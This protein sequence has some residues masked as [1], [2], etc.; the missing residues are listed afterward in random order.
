MAKYVQPNFIV[1]SSA[2]F[3]RNA[4]FDSSVYLQ[5]VTH[6]NAPSAVSAGTPYAMVL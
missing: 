2:A 6:I 4:T 3:L 5:G 1:D